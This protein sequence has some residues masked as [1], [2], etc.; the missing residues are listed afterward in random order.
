MT[1]KISSPSSATQP[2]PTPPIDYEF[3]GGGCNFPLA[4]LLSCT[5]SGFLRDCAK[6]N[7]AQLTA[8]P[9]LTAPFR[10]TKNQNDEI[11]NFCK[12]T[13][14]LV[15]TL[16]QLEFQKLQI[17]HSVWLQYTLIEA[18]V[19]QVNRTYTNAHIHHA[20]IHHTYINHAH[21]NHAPIHE[22]SPSCLF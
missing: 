2:C 8:R 14:T 7:S 19:C 4:E 15:E 13:N 5:R 6:L 22:M 20:H 9:D 11:S 16:A 17:R 12:A 1:Y 21:I 10:K 3:Y 18:Y